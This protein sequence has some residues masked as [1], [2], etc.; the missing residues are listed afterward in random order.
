MRFVYSHFPINVTVAGKDVEIRNFMGERRVRR[1]V[2]PD[3][4]EAVRSADVK[5]ELCLSGNDLAQVSLAAAQVQQMTN[6]R[7]NSIRPPV[8]RND[9]STYTPLPAIAPPHRQHGRF[10]PRPTQY[11]AMT[12]HHASLAGTRIFVSSLTAFTSPTRL[13]LSFRNFKRLN[14]PAGAAAQGRSLEGL[15]DFLGDCVMRRTHP[16]RVPYLS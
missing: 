16:I 11:A 10:R 6:I 15:C 7:Y 13:T 8:T 5:D 9:I 2:L 14:V 4:V 1:V 3:G 12:H